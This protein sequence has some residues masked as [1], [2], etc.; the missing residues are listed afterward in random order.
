MDYVILAAL[1]SAWCLLH[2]ALISVSATAYLQSRLGHRYRFFRLFFN[3]A[4]VLTLIPVLIWSS[5]VR[6]EP[7]FRWDGSLRIVQVL[8]LGTAAALFFLGARRYDAGQL[9]GVRQLRE[10]VPR[11]AGVHAGKLDTAGV[12]G[13]VR[14]P[15]YLAALL[16]IWSRHLDVST[17]VVNAIFTVYLIVGAHLEERKLVREFGEEYEAY[18]R[19]VPMLIPYRWLKST[20]LKR[21]I[22]H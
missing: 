11:E 5:A 1:V 3:A 8:L 22:G 17:L 14:H 15:W 6:T 16:L 2:S 9:L 13:V 21:R 20:V 18:Q 19:R 10:G 7:F 12:L 4:S